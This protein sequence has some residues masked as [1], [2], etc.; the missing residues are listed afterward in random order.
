M[1][2]KNNLTRKLEYG[3]IQFVVAISNKESGRH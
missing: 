1:A 2:P 3:I